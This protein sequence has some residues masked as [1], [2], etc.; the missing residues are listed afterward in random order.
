MQAPPCTGDIV[1]A[2]AV[3]SRDQR[4][5]YAVIIGLLILYQVAS[6]WLGEL[7]YRTMAALVDPSGGE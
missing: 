2:V 7:E 4:I 6:G 3:W 1:Y 5:A